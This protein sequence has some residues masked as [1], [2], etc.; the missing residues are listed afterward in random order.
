[1]LYDQWCCH[2]QFIDLNA[3]IWHSSAGIFLGSNFHLKSRRILQLVE[4]HARAAQSDSCMR[5]VAAE[6]LRS[7]L[8][9]SDL[10]NATLP[11][12]LSVE[13]RLGQLLKKTNT[14]DIEQG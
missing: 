8:I 11:L 12:L 7:A 4:A 5:A 10:R 2:A 13:S 6:I 1:M 9:T 3:I 14:S